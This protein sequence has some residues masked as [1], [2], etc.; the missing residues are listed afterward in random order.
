ML[1]FFSMQL[2]SRCLTRIYKPSPQG[3]RHR[4]LRQTTSYL[5]G[6]EAVA[7]YP[8]ALNREVAQ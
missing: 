4:G 6:S 7:S 1:P 8:V 3:G 5:A 2:K